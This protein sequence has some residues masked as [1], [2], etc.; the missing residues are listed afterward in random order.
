MIDL[1][2]H[3]NQELHADLNADHQGAQ[4]VVMFIDGRI[5]SC[6]E[7]LQDGE[8]PLQIFFSDVLSTERC[9]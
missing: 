8:E 5:Y 6:H 7:V 2:V 3:H 9:F 1:E 4:T